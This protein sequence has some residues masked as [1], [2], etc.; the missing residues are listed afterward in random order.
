MARKGWRRYFEEPID[1]DHYKELVKTCEAI[2]VDGGALGWY[3]RRIFELAACK[4]VP[5][6]R[7]FFQKQLDFYKEQGLI[8]NENCLFFKTIED[9]KDLIDNIESRHINLEEIGE[10]VYEW[11]KKHRYIHVAKKLINFTN[12]CN[13]SFP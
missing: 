1:I 5:V 10:R 3:T 2:I 6:I 7:I 4:T 12:N 11:S 9:L 8:D 13:T